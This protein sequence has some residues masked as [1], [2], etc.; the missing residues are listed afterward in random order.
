MY[1]DEEEGEYRMMQQQHRRNH[2]GI[3]TPLSME[4]E[5]LQWPPR[6]NPAIS[7][8]PCG[9]YLERRKP[10]TID[11]LFQIMQEY[12]ISDKGKRRRLE[13]MNEQ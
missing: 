10:K 4:F 1:S 9:E 12:C 7:L 5:E 6:F 3:G 11:K 8:G 2:G 13:E